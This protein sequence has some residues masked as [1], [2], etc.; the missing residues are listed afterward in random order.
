MTTVTSHME[1]CVNLFLAGLKTQATKDNYM[2][3]L[4]YFKKWL[5]VETFQDIID[6]EPKQLQRKVEEYILYR[7]KINHPNSVGGYYHP[8]Q[9]FLEMNDVLINF[10]KMRRLLPAKQKT[11]VERGWNEDEIRQMLKVC[12]TA[13]QHA[14]IHF[15]NGSGGRVGIFNDLKMKHIFLIVDEKLTP[16]E[17]WMPDMDLNNASMG[18]VG[19]ADEKEEYYTYLPP[20]GTGIFF[21]YVR[22]RIADG[23][24]ITKESPAFR[25]VYKF[26]GQPVI[27]QTSKSLSTMVQHIVTR[28]GLRDPKMKKHGRYPVPANHGFRHRFDEII[29]NVKG[30]N[31]HR[32]EKIFAHKSRLIPLDEIYNNPNMLSL[33]DEYKKIIPF[34]IIDEAEKTKAELNAERTAKDELQKKLDNQRNTV[35]EQVADILNEK[36][37]EMRA[38]GYLPK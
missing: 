31:P 4:E 10:K 28:A 32:A 26:G 35:R 6:L 3:N 21:T 7:R 36:L 11:A 27:P 19:Y 15:E 2:G 25:Q 13:L 30:I 12:G 38:S 17:K 24:K 8:I 5:D 33:F 22:K 14:V 34:I 1:Y 20:E 37:N 29:K 23:E 9:T 16:F 18:I